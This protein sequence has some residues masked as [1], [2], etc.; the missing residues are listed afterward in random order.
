MDCTQITQS[1]LK[2]IATCIQFSPDYLIVFLAV[3]DCDPYVIERPK[4]TNEEL[5]A[6]I[7]AMKNTKTMISDGNARKL[8]V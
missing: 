6:I 2:K 3:E 7:N 1:V 8:K 5:S 4:L